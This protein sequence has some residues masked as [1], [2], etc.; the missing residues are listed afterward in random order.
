M[1]KTLINVGISDTKHSILHFLLLMSMNPIR[2]SELN[3]TDYEISNKK[4]KSKEEI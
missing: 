1:K 4:Y 3:E 2:S